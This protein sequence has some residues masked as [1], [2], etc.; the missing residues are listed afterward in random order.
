MNFSASTHIIIKRY[1]WRCASSNSSWIILIIS[2]LFVIISIAKII[3]DKKSLGPQKSWESLA[4]TA[5]AR[6]KIKEFRRR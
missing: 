3:C 6:K 5:K 1:F 4:A 2:S